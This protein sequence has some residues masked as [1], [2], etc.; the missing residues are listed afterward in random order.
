MNAPPPICIFPPNDLFHYSFTIKKA[1]W[2]T[3]GSRSLWCNCIYYDMISYDTIWINYTNIY[4]YIYIYTYI[5]TYN[6]MYIYVLVLLLVL[7]GLLLICPVLSLSLS[8]LL[9]LLFLLMF[10][11][12][13]YTYIYIYIYVHTHTYYMYVRIY[14]Y[15]GHMLGPQR[16]QRVVR[17][18]H[19]AQQVAARNR[20]YY[21]E[22]YIVN[23]YSTYSI[24]CTMY[25]VMYYITLY[26]IKLRRGIGAKTLEGIFAGLALAFIYM[27]QSMVI[28]S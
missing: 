11:K 2:A 9:L 22:T 18:W 15:T 28:H 19:V 10:S 26:Y 1:C 12:H 27:Q 16:T 3:C 8:V 23:K 4:I 21:I 25:S 13:I 6:Y 7:L 20:L 5:H 17:R 14:I 24:I